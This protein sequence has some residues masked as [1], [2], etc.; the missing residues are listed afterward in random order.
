M[1]LDPESPNPAERIFAGME[2]VDDIDEMSYLD[3]GRLV[4]RAIY[5]LTGRSVRRMVAGFTAALLATG[6][7]TGILIWLALG[8]A[9]PT[10]R[11][12]TWIFGIL[13]VVTGAAVLAL[14]HVLYSGLRDVVEQIGLGRLLGS[15]FAARLDREGTGS[16]PLPDFAQR[17]KAFTAEAEHKSRPDN[18]ASLWTP[19]ARLANRVTF[20]AARV[21]LNRIAKDCVVDGHIDVARFTEGVGKRADQLLVR[22]LRTVLWD[23]VRGVVGFALVILWLAIGLVWGLASALT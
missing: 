14:G 6:L 10:T 13:V 2:N 15:A 23:L 21:V 20:F 9:N 17:L 22:Y 5:E 12:A 16:L 1:K 7:P 18:E 11:T 8:Q 19:I 4:G 3:Q